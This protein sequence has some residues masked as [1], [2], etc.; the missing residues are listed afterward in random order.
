MQNGHA[1]GCSW[2]QTLNH[3]LTGSVNT[4][5]VG[6]GQVTIAGTAGRQTDENDQ[7]GLIEA[8]RELLSII[9]RQLRTPRIV[10]QAKPDLG[11]VSSAKPCRTVFSVTTLGSMKCSR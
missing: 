8:S 7:K 4:F 1:K 10:L 9:G 2:L 11:Y 5:T 3:S 6:P